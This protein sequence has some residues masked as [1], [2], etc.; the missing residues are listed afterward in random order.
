MTANEI[1]KA[2]GERGVRRFTLCERGI[3]HGIIVDDRRLHELVFYERVEQ[4]DQN[5]AFRCVFVFELHAQAFCRRARIFIRCPFVI[6]HACVFFHRFRHGHA[7]PRAHVDLRALIGNVQRAANVFR[8]R[9][10]QIFDH[11]HH[12]E[13]IAIRFVHF[14][15]SKFRVMVGVHTFVSKN[16]AHFIDPIHSADDQAL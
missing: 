12:V 6:I 8:N 10:I 13:I 15:R 2:F 16:S 11:V 9:F 14:N 5:P 1:F 3:F 4:L 7:R